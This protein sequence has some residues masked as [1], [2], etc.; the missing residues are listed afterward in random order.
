MP[1]V[2]GSLSTSV[3]TGGGAQGGEGGDTRGGDARTAGVVRASTPDA[4]DTAPAGESE[5]GGDTSNT[6]RA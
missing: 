4:P 5:A 1:S 2:V 6:Y 3:D